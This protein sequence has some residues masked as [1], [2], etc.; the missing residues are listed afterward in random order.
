[1]NRKL[2]HVRFNDHEQI[3]EID[4]F[5]ADQKDALW[6]SRQD[7]NALRERQVQDADSCD[8]ASLFSPFGEH[9]QKEFVT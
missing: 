8:C 1:M 3:Q 6:Y 5:A 9:R 2:R 7:L 4:A